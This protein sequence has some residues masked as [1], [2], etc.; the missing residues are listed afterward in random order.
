MG[1]PQK[2]PVTWFC[3]RWGDSGARDRCTGFWRA[4]VPDTQRKNPV[5]HTKTG[6]LLLRLCIYRKHKKKTEDNF[7]ALGGGFGWGSEFWGRAGPVLSKSEQKQTGKISNVA[8]QMQQVRTQGAWR[9][10]QTG[11]KA[12]CGEKKPQPMAAA[13]VVDEIASPPFGV[14]HQ[15]PRELTCAGR[16]LKRP[17]RQGG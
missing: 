6:P 5:V 4:Q 17:L 2:S 15:S 1:Y 9:A 14:I 10:S 8:A 7:C 16:P 11:L 13:G 3:P 12:P